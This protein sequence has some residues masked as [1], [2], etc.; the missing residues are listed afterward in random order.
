MYTQENTFLQ[1]L[2][3]LGYRT[4][5]IIHIH[6]LIFKD[7]TAL[8]LCYEHTNLKKSSNPVSLTQ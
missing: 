1:R 6:V 7:D 8:V 2:I 3:T 4:L 5:N